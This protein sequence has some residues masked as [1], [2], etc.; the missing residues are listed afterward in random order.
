MYEISRGWDTKCFVNAETSSQ[1]SDV[2]NYARQNM[3]ENLHTITGGTRHGRFN[4]ERSDNTVAVKSCDAPAFENQMSQLAHRTGILK[5]AITE[6]A[7]HNMRMEH[8][9]NRDKDVPR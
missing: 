6:V 1:I 5:V 8:G 4:F 9:P 2:E 3:N 7:G